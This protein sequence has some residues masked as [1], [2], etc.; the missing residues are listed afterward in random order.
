MLA[1]PSLFSP[2]GYSSYHSPLLRASGNL[3][4]VRST[5]PFSPVPLDTN[6]NALSV[7]VFLPQPLTVCSLYLPPSSPVSYESLDS[8]VSQLPPPFV[9][10]GDFNARS[11]YWR[12]SGNNSNGRV[13]RDV[14]VDRHLDVLNDGSPTHYHAQTDSYTCIDLCVCSPDFPPDRFWSVHDDLCGSD[15]FPALLDLLPVAPIFPRPHWSYR[16]AKWGSFTKSSRSLLSLAPSSSAVADQLPEFAEALCTLARSHIPLRTSPLRPS[17]VWW[18][19]ECMRAKRERRRLYRAFQRSRTPH[20]YIQYRRQCALTRRTFRLAKRGSWME[21]VSSIS[22][23]TPVPK[24]WRRIRKLSGASGCAH[25]PVLRSEGRLVG[26]PREVAQLIARTLSLA[27]VGSQCPSFL[28]HKEQSTQPLD[29]TTSLLKDYNRPFT[30]SELLSALSR[31]SQSAPSDDLVSY[32][33]LQR[34]HLDV[35]RHLLE[36]FNGCFLG[37]TFPHSWRHSVVLPFLKPGKDPANPSSYRPIALTSSLCK[38]F[39]RMVNARLMWVLEDRGLLSPSQFGFRSGRSTLDPLTLLDH[40]IGAAFSSGDFVTAIFLDLEKAYDTVWRRL[41][42]QQL[43]LLG[44]RG[45]LPLFLSN[46]LA[47]RTFSVDLRGARSSSFEQHEGVPQGSVLSTTLFLLAVNSFAGVLPP[48]VRCSLYVDD[49]AI[50]VTGSSPAEVTAILQP[51]LDA[52]V[53]HTERLGF[54]ISCSKSVGIVFSR[55]RH[56]PQVPLTLGRSPLRFVNETRFLG[57]IFDR[58]MTW[59]PHIEDLVRRCTPILAMFSKLSRHHWGADRKTL[60]SLHRS[61]LLSKID[62]GAHIYGSASKSVLNKLNSLHHRGV[63]LATGAF[64]SSPVSSLLADSGFLPLSARRDELCLRFYFRAFRSGSKLH[65]MVTSSSPPSVFRPRTFY[66]YTVRVAHLL[67][68]LRLPHASVL[69]ERPL[70]LPPWTRLCAHVCESFLPAP[71]AFLSDVSLRGFSLDHRD[72]CHPGRSVFTDGSKCGDGVG[73]AAI[74]PSHVVRTTLPPFAS[75][76]SAELVAIRIALERLRSYPPGE[77]TI[78][79]DSRGALEVIA[80]L[81]P[82]HPVAVRIAVLIH[83]LLSR[84]YSVS[85]CWVPGHCQIQGNELADHHARLAATSAAPSAAEPSLFHRDLYPLLRSLVRMEYQRT[86]IASGHPHLLSIRN[87]LF[88]WNTSLSSS[89]RREIVL[90]RLRIGHTRLTHG[91]LM[92]GDPPTL[93]DRC[94]CR[95][96]VSHLLLHCPAFSRLRRRFFGPRPSLASVLGDDPPAVDSLCKFLSLTDIYR[97]L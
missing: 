80:R 70:S 47:S 39:E 91:F 60:L 15:H 35:L 33:I 23:S 32:T 37:D 16:R 56:P 64:R 62:Y 87:D 97:F 2:S 77:F 18:N 73:C 49:F 78:Y 50:W 44:F 95:L 54:R 29:F 59:R 36:L 48:S 10:V 22:S 82:T 13:V 93:C 79:S 90:C 94:G 17:V 45:H 57:L 9:L 96:T 67:L 61:L 38:L 52:V 14:I 31:C 27:S 11:S 41:I 72:R 1:D 81:Y 55:R 5:I 30:L 28:R 92:S 84:S 65:R 46:F 68:R 89:R 20:A 40:D 58:R 8:L 53:L 21:Y 85:F 43:H 51:A 24:I 66:S 71:K 12:D 7:R 19:E 75:V 74:L 34:V 4:Y 3:I 86:W 88:P 6:L 63:R 25:L 42:L 83:D 76:L 26:D 69:I